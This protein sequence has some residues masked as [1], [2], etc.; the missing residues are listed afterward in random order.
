M[1]WRGVMTRMGREALTRMGRARG[2]RRVLGRV[3]AADR[4]AV[5]R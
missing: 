5:D 3:D 2:C 4:P 1:G